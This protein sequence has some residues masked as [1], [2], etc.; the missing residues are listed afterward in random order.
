MI[1][2]RPVPYTRLGG[3][4]GVND[5]PPKVCSHSCA[6]R[7]SGRTV[8]MPIEAQVPTG[9]CSEN[10]VPKVPSPTLLHVWSP[11]CAP[12]LVISKIGVTSRGTRGP[13]PGKQVR[14]ERMLSHARPVR[15]H[16]PSDLGR[17]HGWRRDGTDSKGFSQARLE[18]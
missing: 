13:P 10:M 5:I 14:S 4:L 2:F 17:F 15:H 11:S 12:C 9:D 16:S 7:Q 8:K 1:V 3:S 6:Y 18:R